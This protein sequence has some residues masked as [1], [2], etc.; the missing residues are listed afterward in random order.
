MDRPQEKKQAGQQLLA[1]QP[2]P[3]TTEDARSKSSRLIH[4]PREDS[5]IGFTGTHAKEGEDILVG[6]TL[7]PPVALLLRAVAWGLTSLFTPQVSPGWPGRTHHLSRLAKTLLTRPPVYL[8]T[9]W[10]ILDSEKYLPLFF[11]DYC[12]ICKIR[13]GKRNQ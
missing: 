12:K 2:P 10:H 4:V 11:N 13:G 9:R 7:G 3:P 5:A 1:L 6:P 8:F